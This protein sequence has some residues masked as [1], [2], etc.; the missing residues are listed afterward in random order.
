LRRIHWRSLSRYHQV[1]L[2]RGRWWLTSQMRA[3][4]SGVPRLRALTTLRTICE[5]QSVVCGDVAQA[6]GIPVSGEQS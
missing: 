4:R 2:T 5:S 1:E 3:I 6:G